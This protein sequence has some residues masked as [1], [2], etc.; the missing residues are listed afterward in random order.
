M[1]WIYSAVIVSTI[2]ALGMLFGAIATG[3]AMSPAGVLDS[4]SKLQGIIVGAVG[5]VVAVIAYFTHTRKVRSDERMKLFEWQASYDALEHELDGRI[6]VLASEMEGLRHILKSL[7]IPVSGMMAEVATDAFDRT[8][9]I[10][11]RTISKAWDA[12]G[13]GPPTTQAA[14]V[15]K[16]R[17]LEHLLAMAEWTAKCL[18]LP[19]EPTGDFPGRHL[20]VLASV[21]SYENTIDGG[22]A[23]PRAVEVIGLARQQ[24]EAKAKKKS[25]EAQK[26]VLS[27]G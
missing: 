25:L 26:P 22:I 1:Q 15:E 8:F 12:V 9:P 5:I 2:L 7:K 6:L 19:D 10:V 18:K 17:A 23:S 16:I 3:T 27:E 11:A 21:N 13:K 24:I 4:L 20:S 14:T